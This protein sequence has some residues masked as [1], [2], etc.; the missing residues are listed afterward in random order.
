MMMARLGISTEEYFGREDFEDIVNFNT[1]ATLNA[2][3]FAVSDISQMGLA[4]VA[5]TVISLERQNRTIAN[6]HKSDYNIDTNKKTKGVQTMN[7]LSYTMQGD[8]RLPNLTLPEQPEAPT[9]RYSQMRAKYL[10]ENRRVLYYN[11]LTSCKLNE[12]L[13]E[14]EQTATEMEERLTRE[15][16]AKEGLTESLKAADMMSWVRKMNNIKSRVRE[17]VMKEIIFA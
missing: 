3:G 9:G 2:L 17:I 8:Y 7:E 1:P 14:T 6:N 12:H 11:L 5:K 16:A 15:L 10:K 13:T 4:E